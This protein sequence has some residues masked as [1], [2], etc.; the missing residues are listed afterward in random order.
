MAES[1]KV[2]NRGQACIRPLAVRVCGKN[3]FIAPNPPFQSS[4]FNQNTKIRAMNIF[5]TPYPRKY[6]RM[7]V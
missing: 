1:S 3:G 6:G 2:D 7:M 5:H 4:I